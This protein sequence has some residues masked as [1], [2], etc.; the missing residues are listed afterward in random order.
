MTV[1]ISQHGNIRGLGLTRIVSAPIPG[2]VGL[3]S[4]GV[5]TLSTLAEYVRVAAD[6]GSLLGF[7]PTSILASSTTALSSTNALRIAGNQ[8]A[9]LF[10]IPTGATKV[11]AAST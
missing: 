9:E 4:A 8:A 10:A 6:G 11:L 7:A 2:S 5:L 1:F 3:T